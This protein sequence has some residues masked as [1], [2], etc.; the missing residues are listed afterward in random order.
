MEREDH[1]LTADCVENN[2]SLFTNESIIPNSGDGLWT[3]API[4]LKDGYIGVNF[5]SLF[6]ISCFIWLV[7]LKVSK[8]KCANMFAATLWG[9][10]L[11]LEQDSRGIPVLAPEDAIFEGMRDRLVCIKS[12]PIPPPPSGEKR[13][14]L[15]ILLSKSCAA[16][17]ANSLHGN[18]GTSN[19]AASFNLGL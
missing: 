8:F 6:L 5:I 17:Y 3:T 1:L 13:F 14:G 4:Q 2:R 15:Y 9:K 16:S 12:T 10:V 18:P 11:V 7:R 19:F